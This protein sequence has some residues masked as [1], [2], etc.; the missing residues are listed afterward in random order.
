MKQVLKMWHMIV[1]LV[2]AFAIAGCGGGA[3]SQP[4]TGNPSSPASKGTVTIDTQLFTVNNQTATLKAAKTVAG[5]GGGGGSISTQEMELRKRIHHVDFWFNDGTCYGQMQTLAV[6]QGHLAG[7][8]SVDPGSYTMEANFM[9]E[10]GAILYRSVNQ[11]TVVA[12]MSSH[13]T[14][15]AQKRPFVYLEG[16]INHPTGTYTETE[17]G[18]G[19]D[20]MET[21]GTGNSVATGG[22]YNAATNR[23]DFGAVYPTSPMVSE[24]NIILTDD[25]GQ[26]HK[27]VFTLDLIKAI[28]EANANGFVSYDWPAPGTIDIGVIFED[29]NAGF[30]KAVNAVPIAEPVRGN[31]QTTLARITLANTTTEAAI[32]KTLSFRL[33]DTRFLWNLYLIRDDLSLILSSPVA[34]AVTDEYG[35]AIVTFTTNIHIPPQSVLSINLM[36]DVSPDYP[37]TEMFNFQVTGASVV[38][39]TNQPVPFLGTDG[40]AVG[41][42]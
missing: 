13:E 26:D 23:F 39:E 8:L 4:P 7:T 28:D 20:I 30:V 37:T 11:I 42:Y 2:A 18:Y 14:L 10:T 35:V 3:A 25:N 27:A 22:R 9:T 40:M 21:N 32:V 5:G 41:I 6:S 24:A 33:W 17:N 15:V 19:I 12:G 34:T 31:A 29:D 38:T 16:R 36:G 1:M